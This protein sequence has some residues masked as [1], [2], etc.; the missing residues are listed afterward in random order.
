MQPRFEVRA[1]PAMSLWPEPLPGR[2]PDDAQTPALQAFLP[3]RAEKIGP[4]GCVIVC[5]GGGYNHLADHE[6]EP[7]ARLLAG[8]GLA[9][10]VLRY[11]VKP[12]FLAASLD[13]GRRAVR[14]VRQLAGVWP[15]DPK[16]VG[17][18]G[19]SAGGHLAVSVST[20]DGPGPAGDA[21]DARRSR[22]D[23]LIGCY[24]PVSL[25]AMG[26]ADRYEWLTGENPGPELLRCIE[27]DRQVTKENPPTFLWHCWD[28]TVVPA[29]QSVLLA[30]ALHAAGVDV[31]L[32]LFA[33][34]GQCLRRAEDSEVAQRW[35]SLLIDWLRRVGWLNE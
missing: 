25:P 26:R 33:R 20:I 34:G 30:E 1:E 3:V 22:P 23:A 17:M 15:L 21:I 11:R 10:F 9:A 13:D 8:Q 18:L 29:E 5:P 7:V 2:L 28:D 16:R 14:L 12:Y 32:H 31:Q 27:L 35:P 4:L 24:A 19:F 6:A